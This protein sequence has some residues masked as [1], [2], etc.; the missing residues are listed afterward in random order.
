MPLTLDSPRHREGR[1]PGHAGLAAVRV[2]VPTGPEPV[3]AQMLRL[4][5][6]DI[7]RCPVCH[8]GCLH[9]AAAFRPGRIPAPTL[10]T[11]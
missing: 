3:T 5:D 4:T 6:V 9:A 1:T 2:A 11:S 10:N 7:T 8:A